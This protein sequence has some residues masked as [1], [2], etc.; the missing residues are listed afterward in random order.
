MRAYRCR[1][2]TRTLLHTTGDV[3][4]QA[5]A[6][7]PTH[8]AA[9][10]AATTKGRAAMHIRELHLR[11]CGRRRDGVSGR[12]R[13]IRVPE[14]RGRYRAVG[15]TR[16]FSGLLRCEPRNALCDRAR[17]SACGGVRARRCSRLPLSYVRMRGSPR[18]D[19]LFSDDVAPTA[20]PA[21]GGGRTNEKKET[22]CVRGRR[23]SA[24]GRGPTDRRERATRVRR[25][26]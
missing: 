9:H 25:T 7:A 1:V 20:A 24:P 22:R 18:K 11:S 26:S 5:T 8:A 14:W 16:T 10:A 23:A 12:G 4:V 19:L 15:A 6:H 3:C 13:A 21:G 2:R 17:G